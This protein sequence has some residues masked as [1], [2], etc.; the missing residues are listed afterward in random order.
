MG[1]FK[2]KRQSSRPG[3]YFDRNGTLVD[4]GDTRDWWECAR[5]STSNDLKAKHC[6]GCGAHAGLAAT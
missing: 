5:C 1:L 6:H 2:R 4:P 3:V